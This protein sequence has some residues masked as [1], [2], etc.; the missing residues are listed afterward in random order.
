M[1]THC[2]IIGNPAILKKHECSVRKC[3][4]IM[5]RFDWFIILPSVEHTRLNICMLL[6]K[7]KISFSPLWV[8]GGM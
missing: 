2:T 4:T 8:S 5:K 3:V 1:N 6:S 7:E